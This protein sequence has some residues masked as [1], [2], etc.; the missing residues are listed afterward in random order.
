LSLPCSSPKLLPCRQH[1]LGRLQKA[2]ASL[3]G[4]AA[5]PARVGLVRGK[6]L[7]GGLGLGWWVTRVGLATPI[8]R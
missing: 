1:M 5:V 7:A 8:G 6:G 3:M 2:L 4:L